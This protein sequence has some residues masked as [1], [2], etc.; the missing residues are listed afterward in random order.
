MSTPEITSAKSE[1]GKLLPQEKLSLI[2]G[3]MVP[4]NPDLYKAARRERA[5][6]FNKIGDAAW[7]LLNG[8]KALIEKEMRY[9]LE[10]LRD[11]FQI[12]P[13]PDGPEKLVFLLA[14]YLRAKCG[15]AVLK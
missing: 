2:D 4:L 8:D 3:F 7:V 1:L 9:I 13:N 10:V 11:S 14:N 15:Y 12:V 5:G 6:T